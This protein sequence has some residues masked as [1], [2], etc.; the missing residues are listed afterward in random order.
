MSLDLYAGP[1]GKYYQ[2]DFETPQQRLGREQGWETSIVYAGEEPEWLTPDNVVQ[3]IG[4]FKDQ[5]FET[6]GDAAPNIHN[7]NES[8]DEY[9]TEQVFHECHAALLLITAYTYRSELSR[10]DKLPDDIDANIAMSEASEKDYY[11]GPLAIL[12]SQLFLPDD[13]DRIFALKDPMGW[14]VVITTTSALKY[15]LEYLAQNVWQGETQPDFW[16]NRGAVPKGKVMVE[17][18]SV[19]P[20]AKSKWIS[21]DEEHSIVDEVK[22]NAEYAYGVFHKML[23]FAEKHNVPIRQDG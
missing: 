12:E 5:V 13:S 1:L 21:K 18:K 10:P 2:R 19:L 11:I 9:L 20:W 14:Q 3:V 22:W 7:W 15:A 8:T 16:Y 17:K 23:N 4:V 6:M